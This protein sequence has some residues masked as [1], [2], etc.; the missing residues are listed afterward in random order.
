[1]PPRNQEVILAV[2]LIW[3]RGPQLK[4]INKF[5]NLNSIKLSPDKG[6]VVVTLIM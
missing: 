6:T 2:Q 3:G 1:M 5:G 4:L